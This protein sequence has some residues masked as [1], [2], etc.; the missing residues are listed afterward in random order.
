L[1]CT[2]CGTRFTEVLDILSYLWF[3]LSSQAK[4]LLNQ[5]HILGR[6]YGWRESDILAMKPW[7]RQYYLDLVT[8]G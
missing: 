1:T 5:V 4:G 8:N 7:R 2:E 3:E 6:Y